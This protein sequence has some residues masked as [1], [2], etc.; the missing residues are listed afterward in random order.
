MQHRADGDDLCDIEIGLG[1]ACRDTQ[2]EIGTEGEAAQTQ[3]SAADCLLDD[4]DG[5]DDFV[6][7]AAVKNALVQVVCIAMIAHLQTP[8]FKAG[9]VQLVTGRQH[10]QR[11][12]ATEPTVYQYCYRCILIGL[13][14]TQALQPDAVVALDHLDTRHARY[15]ASAP[16]DE[17]SAQRHAGDDRLHI[18]VSPKS[19]SVQIRAGS[20]P[21]AHYI[22]RSGRKRTSPDL[23]TEA[24]V[25][26][27]RLT[28]RTGALRRA[29]GSGQ[30]EATAHP[31]HH[32]AE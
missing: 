12:C 7:A 4:T 29:P 26:Q 32:C 21:S 9:F 23:H 28:T 24:G 22:N 27:T 17:R 13:R 8:D 2:R 15:S 10:V 25:A 14:G 20:N 5:A 6:D 11:I 18:A 1:C 3:L 31:V 19:S 16:L 30:T